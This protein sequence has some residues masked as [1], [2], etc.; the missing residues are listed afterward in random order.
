MIT[1]GLLINPESSFGTGDN[2]SISALPF[3][4]IPVTKVVKFGSFT[5]IEEDCL[6]GK[7]KRL[8]L[9]RRVKVN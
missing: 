1:V 7:W 9:L 4:E 8:Q 2:R 5:R 6:A 3:W